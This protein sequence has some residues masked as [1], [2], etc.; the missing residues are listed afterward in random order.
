MGWFDGWPFKSGEKMQKEQQEFEKR[1]FPF[2]MEQRDKAQAVLQQLSTGK[3]S[4]QEMMFAFIHAKDNYTQEEDADKALARSNAVLD[5]LRW[6]KPQDRQLVQALLLL[7]LSAPSLEEYPTAEQVQ[8]ACEIAG[9]V[10]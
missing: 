2:G 1:V 7:D 10:R 3:Q 5:K 4:I 8:A 9:S 6:R